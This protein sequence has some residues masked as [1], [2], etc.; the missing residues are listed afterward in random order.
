M[1]ISERAAQL[2]PSLTLSIDSKAKAMKAEGIDVCGFGAGEPDFD[3]PEHIKRAAIEALEAGFTKYTPNAGI[4]ELRQAIADK[5]AADNGL[6]YRASQIVVSNGA[7][8]ACY[9]AILATCQPGDEVIIPAPYWVSYPDM[10]RLVGAEPVIVPTSERNAWKMRPEDFENA[11]TPRTKM[12]IMN[13]PGNPTGSV[14]TRE[15]LEAIINVAAEED[16]YVLSDEIYE[17]LVYDDA[18][19]VSVASL[20]KEA[21]DLTITING[22]SKSYAM[23][24]W[25]LG[26]LAAPDAVARAVDSIQS[27]TSSN[28]S[29]FSQYGAVA[30]LKGDQQPLADMREEFDMRRNYMFDR[31]SKISNV[32]AVKPQGAF[33]ILVNI[34]QLGLTSQNFAD[35]LLSKA[36]VA[37]VPGAAFGDDRTVRFS[38]ATSLD[39]I[40]KGLDRF[41]DFCRTL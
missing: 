10:V 23:T 35:R 36:N 13:T 24:G 18:K 28:P 31:L 20:S 25:R 30:A 19:H 17:K 11:M 32:T 21:Y 37:V 40:K 15:E 3:T 14:Y 5:F 27:H 4:P 29:S 9:N 7:K 41:Q 33:Y 1:E 12:L 22:F 8:H 2:T 16:I 38:Y 6:N 39:V 34:S 26:Y